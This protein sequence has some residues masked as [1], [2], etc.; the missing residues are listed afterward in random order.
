M[1]EKMQSRTVTKQL[2]V[3]LTDAEILNYGRDCARAQ[4]EHANIKNTAKTVAK[5]YAS[6][7]AEQE[8]IIARLTV[9]INSGKETRDI[10]CLELKNW[11]KGT[12]TVSRNDTHEVIE[13]RPMREDEKQM[14]ISEVDAE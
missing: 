8:A 7:I 13:S 10:A 11:N 12:V 2:P 9:I 14:E 3:V 4:H 1:K 5:E 6:K